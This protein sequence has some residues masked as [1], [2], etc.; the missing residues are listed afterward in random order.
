MSSHSN[1]KL[2]LERSIELGFV[3][4]TLPKG[5][6]QLWDAAPAPLYPW[7]GMGRLP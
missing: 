3:F 7:I 6:T 5:L 2:V 4:L 1:E